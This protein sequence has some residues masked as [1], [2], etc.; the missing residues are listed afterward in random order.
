MTDDAPARAI[1]TLPVLPAGALRV[2][3]GVAEGDPVSFADELILDDVYGLAPDTESRRLTLAVAPGGALT[4]AEGS[5]AGRAGNRVH[6]DS[7]LTFMAPDG[8][9]CEAV[10]LVEVE[11]DE[12][13]AVH[14][15]PLAPLA[16]RTALRLVGVD[17][18]AASRRFAEVACV[19]FA[20]GT[21]IALADGAERRIEDLRPGDRVLT[22]DDGP[23]T[24]R[25]IG[26]NTVRATGAFAPVLIR[27]GA[28]NN[29]RDL[30]LSPDHRVF[31]YQR[32][33]ALGA[34]RAEVLVRVRHLVDGARVVRREGGFVDYFQLL[35]DAHHI[36][37]AEGIAA[38]SLWLDARTRDA[39]PEDIAAGPGHAARA[40]LDFELAEGLSARAGALDLLRRASTG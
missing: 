39:L 26:A 30:L 18:R 40:H 12:A 17:R 31:V 3:S 1:Q 6:L 37:Y 13:A 5:A 38:E 23:R 33:D 34:G 14:L 35:F 11:R 8:H 25:W 9:I 7:C 20:R 28:L 27:E 24:L 10:V 15:L 29:A 32:R 36:I 2:T 19:A 4:V 22:R 16:P 21:H